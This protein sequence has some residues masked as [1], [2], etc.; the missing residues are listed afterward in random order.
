MEAQAARPTETADK[1][2]TGWL[3]AAG[4]LAVIGG[5]V[6]ILVPAVASVTIA[7]FI[8]WLLVFSAIS[9]VIDA[10]AHRI[11]GRTI[12]RLI[13]AALTLFAGI[14][15]L[16]APLEGTVTLTFVLGLYFLIMGAMRVMAWWMAR[17]EEGAG[18]VAVSGVASL[19]IGILILVELPSSA[20]WAIGLLVG[21]DFI[22]FGFNV[23]ALAQ[24]IKRG[25]P[26][27]APRPAT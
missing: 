23:I 12:W 6:A 13:W 8:G 1:P 22:F 24:A 27:L 17:G 3:T 26:D 7:I 16:L 9:I 5:V 14:Y 2:R 25:E 4:V 18:L 19:L 20:D 21:I 10:F 15:L 11:P